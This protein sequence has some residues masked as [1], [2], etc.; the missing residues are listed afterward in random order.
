MYMKRCTAINCEVSVT[1]GRSARA[2]VLALFARAREQ[3]RL[4][5]ARLREHFL[6]ALRQAR[7]S[8]LAVWRRASGDGL[9]RRMTLAVLFL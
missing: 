8:H 2:L 9:Q 1:A 5:V 6:P 4:R 7:L 3:L